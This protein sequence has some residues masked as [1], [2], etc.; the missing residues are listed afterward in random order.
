M[1]NLDKFDDYLSNWEVTWTYWLLLLLIP[2][3]MEVSRHFEWMARR[4][5]TL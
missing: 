5:M 2:E 4:I 3:A 1:T